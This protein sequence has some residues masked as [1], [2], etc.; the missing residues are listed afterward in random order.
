LVYHIEE[1][2]AM[3]RDNTIR[4]PQE[5]EAAVELAA[6]WRTGGP[7]KPV[8]ERALADGLNVS[9]IKTM[10]RAMGRTPPAAT[11]PASPADDPVA[12]VEAPKPK[13]KGTRS[14]ATLASLFLLGL[15]AACAGGREELAVDRETG[16]W[17]VSSADCDFIHTDGTIQRAHARADAG[18]ATD[19]DRLVLQR[20][21]QGN[22]VV[23]G[24]D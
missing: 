16:I 11:P 3:G 5:Q 6:A 15:L 2:T 4:E 19:V 8:L 17:G 20:A 21:A 23:Y 7:A 10:A 9:R 14:R 12:A 13:P 18:E 22:C 1:G 24:A